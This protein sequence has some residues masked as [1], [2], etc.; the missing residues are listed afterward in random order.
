MSWP[1]ALLGVPPRRPNAT[2]L[3]VTLTWLALAMPVVAAS[4]SPS[5]GVGGDPRSSGQG[6][7]LVGD[8]AFALLA[9]IAIG[10]GAL[11]LTLV[12]VRV[13]THRPR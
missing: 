4:P 13:T 8:P 5:A 12:Y 7:G 1:P 3:A 11:V 9:V 10:L 2:R 6:P